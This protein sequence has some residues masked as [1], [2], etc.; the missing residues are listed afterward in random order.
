MNRSPNVL[1]LMSDQHSPHAIGLG[2]RCNTVIR[3]PYLDA[4]AEKGTYFDAAYCQVPL[5]SPSRMCLLTGKYA[6]HCSA[7]R[8]EGVLFPEHRTIA[9]HFAEHGYTT[10]LVGKAH[11]GGNDQY[12]GFQHRPYGDL[13]GHAGHQND[14]LPG[15]KLLEEKDK[16]RYRAR[17]RLAGVTEWPISMMQESIVNLEATEFVREN[18]QRGPWFLVASYSRPHFPLTAPRRFFDHYWPDNVDM[19]DMPPGHLE[20]T[21]AFAKSLREKFEVSDIPPDETRRARAAYYACCEFLDEV[22]GDLLTILDRDGFLENTVVVYTSDHGEMAGEHGQWWKGTYYD[23]ASRVPLIVWD[24]RLPASFGRQVKEPVGLIDLFPTLC[25]RAGIPAA[26]N[27][28]GMDL[29]GLM[30]GEDRNSRG[31]VMTELFWPQSEGHMRM[32]RTR[33]FKYVAFPDHGPILF[34]LERDPGEFRDVARRTEYRDI[35][36]ELER[37]LMEGF[38]WEEQ[39]KRIAADEIRSQDYASTWGKG[40]PNQYRL[41]DGRVIDAETGLFSPSVVKMPY[42]KARPSESRVST[43]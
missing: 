34:D 15:S 12:C 40:T 20:A 38:D 39:Q 2:G 5:C 27:L 18:A 3:T 42:P 43:R 14:P 19:P 37:E 28:D 41:P 36:K 11:F 31:K 24:R 30:V 33:R 10:C 8:N 7:Y 4:L 35:E 21:H 25:G 26:Q 6:R 23:A 29:S 1:V 9:E 13:R 16:G 22:I 32:I 17:T